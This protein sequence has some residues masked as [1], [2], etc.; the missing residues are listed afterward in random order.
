MLNLKKLRGSKTTRE[1]SVSTGL[2]EATI[3]NAE[4]KPH[5]MSSKTL[6]ALSE[7]YGIAIDE[8]VD[9]RTL[10]RELGLTVPREK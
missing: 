10:R 1:V 7:Y 2:T 8:I 4:D 9:K 3:R 6:F 5:L